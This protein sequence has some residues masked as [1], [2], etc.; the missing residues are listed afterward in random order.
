M[1]ELGGKSVCTLLQLTG[2]AYCRSSKTDV[3]I[4]VN[5]PEVTA[6]MYKLNKGV[7][8]YSREIASKLSQ[9]RHSVERELRADSTQD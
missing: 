4:I 3:F 9:V 7:Y 1:I 2:N 5:I 8:V 6:E